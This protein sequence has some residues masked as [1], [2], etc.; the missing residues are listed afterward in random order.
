M[1]KYSVIVPVFNR[2]EEIEELLKSLKEQSY[3]NFEIIVIEDGSAETCEGIVKQ[4]AND[5][6]I[7]YYYKN[8]SGPG[9]SRNVG[10]SKASGQYL[11]FFD[12]DCIIP[13]DYFERVENYLAS[14]RLDA[15]GGPDNAHISFTG[16]QKAINYAMTSVITTGGV[17]GKKNKLDNFQ[18]RSFNMGISRNVYEK[19]GGFC[20]IHP[21]EDPDLSYRIMDAGFKVGLIKEAFVYHKRRIDFSKFVKQV[22]KFG[23]VRGILIKWYPDKFKITYTFPTLFLLFSLLLI[24]LSVSFSVI[25]STPLLLIAVV[26]FIDALAKTKK[27][28]ISL[29]A[30]VAS[31]IQ[32]YCYGYGF[33]RSAVNVLILKKDERKVFSKFFFNGK[34]TVSDKQ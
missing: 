20:N 9:D 29:L 34:E 6:D 14:D 17:R 1:V 10:M 27:L 21:G 13:P 25:Y 28:C 24:V 26:I 31:F 7:K 5:L 22:Y 30:I 11:I 15:F 16:I 2:P 32:L 19:V 23:V 33:L 12:S 18:P 3:T 8:N 4:Y